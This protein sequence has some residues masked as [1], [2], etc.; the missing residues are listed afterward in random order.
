MILRIRLLPRRVEAPPQHS[1]P[2][3]RSADPSP[4]DTLLLA[5]LTLPVV[6]LLLIS[7]LRNIPPNR[8]SQIVTLNPP[9]VAVAVPN[10]CSTLR[11][12]DRA[13]QIVNSAVVNEDQNEKLVRLSLHRSLPCSMH[14]SQPVP[15]S[16]ARSLARSLV[17]F[18]PPDLSLCLCFSKDQ[19]TGFPR[20]LHLTVQLPHLSN[21]PFSVSS[22]MH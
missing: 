6:A 20:P 5:A 11:Y 16:L 21:S 12:A 17:S 13:K 3:A 18:P 2:A 15:R 10:P 14:P 19:G 22:H 4:T 1:L 7:A 9:A 8:S